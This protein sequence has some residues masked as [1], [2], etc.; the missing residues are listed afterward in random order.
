MRRSKTSRRTNR[1]EVP[2]RSA[3]SST[4]NSLS[5]NPSCR[6]ALRVAGWCGVAGSGEPVG[7]GGELAGAVACPDRPR[8]DPTRADGTAR[9]AVAAGGMRDIRDIRVFAA[10]PCRGCDLGIRDIR[11]KPWIC[12]GCRGSPLAIRDRLLA[13]LSRGFVV[14]SRMSRLSRQVARPGLVQVGAGVA[15]ALRA[16]AVLAH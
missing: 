11:D 3:T 12:R 8:R 10:Q 13:G 5:I 4:V 1:T 7:V 2:S 15:L 6:L 9:L 16:G 14:V